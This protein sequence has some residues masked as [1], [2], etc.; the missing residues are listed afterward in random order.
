[1]DRPVQF[2]AA[3]SLCKTFRT[4]VASRYADSSSDG[5]TYINTAAYSNSAT[6]ENSDTS[7]NTDRCTYTGPNDNTVIVLHGFV[8]WLGTTGVNKDLGDVL[9][10]NF[11][12]VLTGGACKCVFLRVFGVLK[13]VAKKSNKFNV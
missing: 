7:V 13:L 6:A 9:F 4:V 8:V 3:S 5:T 11:G 12:S 10:V 1:M 2:K